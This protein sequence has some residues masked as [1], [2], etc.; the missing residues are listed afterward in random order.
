MSPIKN[1]RR[2]LE[3]LLTGG[4]FTHR[5][6]LSL[7][8]AEELILWEM[9]VERTTNNP[10]T[11]RNRV[12]HLRKTQGIN[13]ANNH[14]SFQEKQERHSLKEIRPT[15]STVQIL[16]MKASK[17]DKN[18]KNLGWIEG[19]DLASNDEFHESKGGSMLTDD[20]VPE[21]GSRRRGIERIK[22][23]Y[24]VTNSCTILQRNIFRGT[25]TGSF[26]TIT[27]ASQLRDLD[28]LTNLNACCSH[29]EPR[30]KAK[31]Q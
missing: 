31:C 2:W 29:V 5:G 10:T 25:I 8:G 13:L 7:L 16:S 21:E 11:P 28:F 6:M 20:N 15:Q 23:P 18:E 22:S 12:H 27:L 26:V 30:Y 1:I 3:S 14:D 24:G 9:E 4:I 19:M 17:R